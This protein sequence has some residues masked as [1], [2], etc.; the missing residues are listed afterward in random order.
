MTLIIK[1]TNPTD[2][3]NNLIPSFGIGL[4]YHLKHHVGLTRF[5][6]DLTRQFEDHV[7]R[8]IFFYGIK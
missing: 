6:Q 8:K 5:R 1:T 2:V 7:R 4:T 3:F